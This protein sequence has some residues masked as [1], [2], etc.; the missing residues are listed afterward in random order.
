M[1]LP[2]FITPAVVAVGMLSSPLFDG[3]YATAKSVGDLVPPVQR[4]DGITAG[5]AM[6]EVWYRGYTCRRTKTSCGA[7][8][9]HAC[10]AGTRAVCSWASSSSRVRARSIGT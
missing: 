7:T 8:A 6:G 4:V 9:S 10:G 5:E 3:A 2:R 1:R